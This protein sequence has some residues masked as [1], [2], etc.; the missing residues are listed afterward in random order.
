MA[1]KAENKPGTPQ[2]KVKHESVITL[3]P[4]SQSAGC[5]QSGDIDLQV[6][7]IVMVMKSANLVQ[8]LGL[9]FP[10]RAGVS[11]MLRLCRARVYP[12]N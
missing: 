11:R 4:P 8:I 6:S 9:G 1:Q 3:N 10:S 7:G 2:T 12:L 5:R